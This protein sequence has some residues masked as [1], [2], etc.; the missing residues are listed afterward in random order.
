MFK[1]FNVFYLYWNIRR[2]TWGLSFV[3]AMTVLTGNDTAKVTNSHWKWTERL[4]CLLRCLFP[5]TIQSVSSCGSLLWKYW[6]CV[7]HLVVRALSSPTGYAVFLSLRCSTTCG[8]GQIW[9]S[10]ATLLGITAVKR[11][12]WKL[13]EKLF[14]RPYLAQELS[15]SPGTCLWLLPEHR[16]ACGWLCTWLYPAH[17]FDFPAWP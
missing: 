14:W 1:H 6:I 16:F 12:L 13:H 10:A 9:C 5:V 3:Q 7:L 15:F 4:I 8:Q 11:A 17:C 2:L